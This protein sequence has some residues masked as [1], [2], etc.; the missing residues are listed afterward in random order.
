MWVWCVLCIMLPD[1]LGDRCHKVGDGGR[2][3]P[4]FGAL[5]G[6]AVGASSY[7]LAAALFLLAYPGVRLD[8]AVPEPP[9]ASRF[10][11]LCPDEAGA[12]QGERLLLG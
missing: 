11:T 1:C 2:V 3:G 12:R 4:A 7:D 8:S 5:V 6:H 9:R 10:A